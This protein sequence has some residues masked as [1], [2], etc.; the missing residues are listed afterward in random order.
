MKGY[1]IHWGCYKRI[2]QESLAS[3]VPQ[4]PFPSMVFIYLHPSLHAWERISKQI[5]LYSLNPCQLS[6]VYNKTAESKMRIDGILT[7]L[8]THERCSLPLEP[9]NSTAGNIKMILIP[10]STTAIL[11]PMPSSN[12]ISYDNYIFSLFPMSAYFQRKKHTTELKQPK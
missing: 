11:V 4:L 3:G 6:K 5:T 12:Y 9:F 8:G 7:V 2:S 1:S 10:F